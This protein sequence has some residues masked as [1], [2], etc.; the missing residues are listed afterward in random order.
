MTQPSLSAQIL[1]FMGGPANVER[2]T[3]CFSRLR[4][5]LRDSTLV[6]QDGLRGLPDVLDIFPRAD[7][8]HVALRSGVVQAHA[9]IAALL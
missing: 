6:D 5:R 4:F 2:L 7:G 8:M 3:H 9:E 1:A